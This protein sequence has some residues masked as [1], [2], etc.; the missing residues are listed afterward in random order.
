MA[1]ITLIFIGLKKNKVSFQLE[2]NTLHKYVFISV[3]KI[4]SIK[5][6]TVKV[7]MKQ[8]DLYQLST[9]QTIYIDILV[10]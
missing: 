8:K 2:T 3:I 9:Q 1:V 7:I 6:L 10:S 4:K 5:S